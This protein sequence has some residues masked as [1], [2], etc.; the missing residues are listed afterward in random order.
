MEE[1]QLLTKAYEFFKAHK[2][3]NMTYY[4]AAQIASAHLEN[5]KHDMALRFHERIAKNYRR[6]WREILDAILA[7]SFVSAKET[8][9]W[10]TAVRAGMELMSPGSSVSIE[11]RERYAKE[12]LEILQTKSP[13]SAEQAAIPLDMTETAP[14]F[15][16]RLSFWSS[17]THI[18]TPVP[19]QL[20]LSSSSSSRSSAFSFSQL[21]IHFNNDRPPVTVKHFDA[22]EPAGGVERVNLGDVTKEEDRTAT[23]R[24]EDG[25]TK[26]EKVVL[27][28]S[29][30]DWQLSLSLKPET[31]PRELVWY[32]KDKTVPLTQAEASSCRITR[33][34]LQTSVD[35]TFAGSA[36]L[37]EDF[38]IDVEVS[39]EDELD[40]QVFLVLFL[41][42]GDDGAHNRVLV[43]S[44]SS[45]SVI[46]SLSLGTLTP[47]ASLR[48]TFHLTSL[49]PPGT[50][51]VDVTVRTIP[52][53]SA[54]SASSPPPAAI[55][56][57][58]EVTR[59]LAIPAVHPVLAAFDT[60]MFH[61]RRP[62]KPLPDLQEPDGWEGAQEAQ[63]VARLQAAGPWDIEVV[64]MRL[65]CESSPAIRVT[66]SS[67]DAFAN[68]PLA[69]T[70][71]PR[72]LFNALFR[73]DVKPQL[74]EQ[75]PP[76]AGAV[77]AVTWRRPGSST[78]TTTAI[79][80]PPIQPLPLLPAITL[81]LAPYLVLHQP[82][83]LTY[84][85]SNPTGR[86]I[87]LSSQLDG[88][89]VPSSFV[90]AGP[91]RFPEWILASGEERSL[92]VRVVPLMAGDWALPRLRVW[93]VEHVSAPPVPPLFD[94][95][96]RPVPA[97]PPPQPRMHEL[98]V[99]VET[100]AV[101]EKDPA[102]AE[103]EADLRSARDGDD[104]ESGR[105]A[106]KAPVVL[107]LPR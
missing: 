44:Q 100:D 82:T 102:Q 92:Q 50:R 38:P 77:L 4:L 43:D 79:P 11:E 73:L 85:F 47:G 41:Q 32:V 16:C 36:Y 40:V 96:G 74:F 80:L 69:L 1:A 76:A 106:V 34:D 70:W 15:N 5:G 48:K 8:E 27:S 83:T 2:A 89:E 14:L 22:A 33:R 72:D 20:A 12:V 52:T 18:S 91:R 31:A 105:G 97:P 46:E 90:F 94:E 53:L 87:T 107:V 56:S 67:L 58:A 99:Q 28:A 81:Q 88:P 25:Q 54:S 84:R 104:G 3:K 63:L 75:Q 42:P 39:N 64:G 68:S 45:T 103:L 7:K 13:S 60:Q 62:L 55:P 78:S 19:F 86:S 95:D 71:K 57:P 59:T 65:S 37:G 29:I 101:E 30:G 49:G 23:L 93:E 35:T 26:V 66:A 98:D 24:W 61:R 9:E 6:G 10:E 17:S 51:F 21:D